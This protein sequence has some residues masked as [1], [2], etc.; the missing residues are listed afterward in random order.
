VLI[1]TCWLDS[2]T[3]YASF[4]IN[5]RWGCVSASHAY[6]GICVDWLPEHP[7]N[8][9]MFPGTIG[10][11]RDTIDHAFCQL[12]GGSTISSYFWVADIRYMYILLGYITVATSIL[13]GVSMREKGTVE[14]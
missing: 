12:N 5:T 9:I 2:T 11:K 8:A 7:S 6:G 13:C 14:L 3:H 1:G 10:A 4:W